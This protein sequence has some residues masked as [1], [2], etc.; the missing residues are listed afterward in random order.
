MTIGFMGL[1]VALLGEYIDERLRILLLPAILI[2]L[3][4]VLYWYLFDDLRFYIW[5]QLIPLLTIP[6][7]MA[8]FPA[9]YSHQSLLLAALSLYVLAKVSEYF[10]AQ[11]FKGTDGF[12]SGHTI[13]HFLSALGCVFIVLMLHKRKLLES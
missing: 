6:I 4:S 2:G 13:K 9:R 11:I 3:S 10:D 7:I 1:F 12:M 8:L 5:V